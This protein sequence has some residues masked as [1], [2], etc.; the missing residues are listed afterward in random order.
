M[1]F[2]T[3]LKFR[4]VSPVPPATSA[5]SAAQKYTPAGNAA[6]SSQTPGFSPGSQSS[7]TASI[8]LNQERSFI[9][10]QRAQKAAPDPVS[11]TRSYILF[12]V[13][14]SRRT[15]TPSQ[16]PIINQSTDSTVFQDLKKCYQTYRGRL[17]LWFSIWRLEYCEVVKV[18]STFLA[19][20]RL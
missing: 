6:T 1:P 12:G 3:W 11:E 13:Q 7:P 17:R 15:L 8:Q 19:S 9:T 4:E 18:N 20:S 14:G 16:I 2:T 10:S 5:S